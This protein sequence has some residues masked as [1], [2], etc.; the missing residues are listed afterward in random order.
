MYPPDFIAKSS[1]Y[2][3]KL[4]SGLEE[5]KSKREKLEINCGKNNSDLVKSSQ[6]KENEVTILNKETPQAKYAAC[7]KTTET[8]SSQSSGICELDESLSSVENLQLVTDKVLQPNFQNCE[9][10]NNQI[11]NEGKDDINYKE[12]FSEKQLMQN[13]TKI[14]TARTV[15]V[16]DIQRQ[17][18]EVYNH[19]AV[20]DN[21]VRKWVRA[22]FKDGWGNVHNEQRSGRPTVITEDLVNVVV[23]K[24]LENR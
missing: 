16:A 24:I 15:Q 10:S 2:I 8:Q 6:M 12:K 22:F 5:M 14:L 7:S 18:S 19:N 23:E 13:I 3:N 11:N 21:K 17:I 4:C 1:Y 9:N 20:S